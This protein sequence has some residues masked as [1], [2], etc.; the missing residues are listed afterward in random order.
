MVPLASRLNAFDSSTKVEPSSITS[1]KA[2]RAVL[3]TPRFK[4]TTSLKL[5]HM[6]LRTPPV[7]SL[8]SIPDNNR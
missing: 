6:L 7:L 4:R 5:S 2:E 3:G 8:T 1:S